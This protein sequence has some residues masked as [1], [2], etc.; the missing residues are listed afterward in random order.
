MPNDF[1]TNPVPGETI[2]IQPGQYFVYSAV[3]N[4]WTELE[5]NVNPPLATPIIAGL[6]TSDD[7]NKLNE[8]ILPPP[9]TT[10]KSEDYNATFASG[11][12]TISTADQAISDTKNG[13]FV[14]VDGKAKL[15]NVAAGIDG[16]TA[17]EVARTL[18]HQAYSFDVSLDVGNIYEY[19]VN[20][21][22]YRVIAKT[23]KQGKRG[24]TGASGENLLKHGPDGLPGLPG[25]NAT[26][27][28]NLSADP[29]P[30]AKR[31]KDRRAIIDI[32][33]E[34]VNEDE[35]YL[36]VTRAVIG[37]PDAAPDKVKISSLTNSKWVAVI[38]SDLTKSG[39]RNTTTCS[40]YNGQV[41]YLD[42]EP[43]LQSIKNEYLREV[44]I[45]RDGIERVVSWWLNVMSGK[46][47][48]QKAALCCALEYCKSRTRNAELRKYIETTRI[49][50]AGFGGQV[51]MEPNPREST[52]VDLATTVMQTVCGTGFGS[53]R[54][55][56]P[57]NA[58]PVGASACVPVLTI[59]NGRP[60]KYN[61]CPAGFTPR[62]VYRA[63]RQNQFSSRSVSGDFET[64]EANSLAALSESPK[65]IGS[66]I[67][68]KNDEGSI[69]LFKP[70][71]LLQKPNNRVLN[72]DQPE[73][74]DLLQ[75]VRTMGSVQDTIDR[76]SIE[77]QTICTSTANI[78]VHLVSEFGEIPSGNG[79]VRRQYS[80][81]T[82]HQIFRYN[83]ELVPDVH[84]VCIINNGP[85]TGPFKLV[86]ATQNGIITQGIGAGWKPEFIK[87]SRLAD[88]EYSLAAN[89]LLEHD[90]LDE[91]QKFWLRIKVIADPTL[92]EPYSSNCGAVGPR[93]SPIDNR[94]CAE[95]PMS[96]GNPLLRET[97]TE[98]RG[99]I[100]HDW[101][102]SN[103]GS[104]V[105][106]D[107][108]SGT[109]GGRFAAM[110]SIV[111]CRVSGGSYTGGFN[112]ARRS[113][114]VIIEQESSLNITKC[115]PLRPP[116]L[117]TSVEATGSLSFRCTL[118]V[119]SDADCNGAAEEFSTVVSVSPDSEF[120][121]SG[122]WTLND[123]HLVPFEFSGVPNDSAVL[124][125]HDKTGYTVV[126][127]PKN[128][129]FA[130]IT[131]ID[132][133]RGSY[134]AAITDCCLKVGSQ[135]TGYVKITHRDANGP[136]IRSMPDYGLLD[137]QEQAS[138]LYKGMTTQITHIGGP[139]SVELG[140][141]MFGDT[142]GSIS[143]TFTKADMSTASVVTE[144]A[145]VVDCVLHHKELDYLKS[146]WAS[147]ECSG[148]VADIKGQDY[149][150]MTVDSS[151]G[152]LTRSTAIAWPTFNGIDMVAV[153]KSGS[154]PF[155]IDETLSQAF[156]DDKAAG[157]FIS[158]VG[159]YQAIE[160]VMFPAI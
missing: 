14:N 156:L 47:D 40:I 76:V 36:V 124:N 66:K 148:L 100:I 143:V 99:G 109:V 90:G 7:Y 29:I 80:A 101:N 82:G 17:E 81:K 85:K 87:T 97:R 153:P 6:M 131:T 62:S 19:L 155:K 23:G 50:A 67:A 30:Y 137:D 8:M 43:I 59:V 24:E 139:V 63:S 118:L 141:P 9:Q 92:P 120:G 64:F 45:L 2:E 111:L 84:H 51:I 154:V 112:Y 78:N 125:L 32:S 48:E 72:L 79:I 34:E 71:D 73:Q 150:I 138:S 93:I 127:D 117:V 105:V 89:T 55:G 88:G 157:R 18:H 83:E 52:A 38:P 11:V 33:T 128:Q 20:N 135:F 103:F 1:P 121:L 69:E 96:A 151:I 26:I 123:N 75:M 113:C 119:W 77:L 42:L 91:G 61:E 86:I 122:V 74:A 39:P 94:V 70:L 152:C 114:Q 149:I 129:D 31:T 35:N 37:N 134:V 10:L 126:L 57:T 132:L 115:S 12:I 25:L 60:Y 68:I 107:A 158:P 3:T 106:P 136:I 41:Y 54:N 146:V 102:T 5:G 58:D 16:D 13:E 27:P 15:M 159:D 53:S 133:P 65:Q 104:K 28:I 110:G 22:K 44:E 98:G 4:A 46:F 21:N 144:E 95:L 108:I 142:S 56:L 160:T 49:N 140:Q 147:G 130:K 116:Q 145:T